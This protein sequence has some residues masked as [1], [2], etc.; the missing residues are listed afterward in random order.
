VP[1]RHRKPTAAQ[2]FAAET[3]LYPTCKDPCRDRPCGNEDAI[4][5]LGP[6]ARA[7]REDRR[8][9]V[10]SGMKLRKRAHLQCVFGA[11]ELRRFRDP[12]AAAR[13]DADRLGSPLMVWAEREM[14]ANGSAEVVRLEDDILRSRGLGAA[15]SPPAVSGA[16]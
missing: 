10:A 5:A 6:Q 3:I 2:L 8:G 16:R 4:G 13:K 7:W 1:R 9:Y 14:P 12:P 15:L 11:H